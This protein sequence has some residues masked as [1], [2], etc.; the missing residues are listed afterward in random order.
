MRGSLLGGKIELGRPGRV[1]NVLTQ[2]FG[3]DE[4]DALIGEM[5]ALRVRLQIE[6]GDEVIRDAAELVD[7]RSAQYDVPA[8][9]HL[10]Q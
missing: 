5:K 10:R 2:H 8:D 1:V 3:R 4:D 7:D 9:F 6:S